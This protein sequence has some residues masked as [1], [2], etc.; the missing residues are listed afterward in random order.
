M[1]DTLN[2]KAKTQFNKL[3]AAAI[4]TLG[5]STSANPW[6]SSDIDKM[7][8]STDDYS[9]I[10]KAC[11]FFYKKDPII[12]STINK[13]VEIGINEL[14]F[15]SNGLS[16]N[17]FKIFLGLKESLEEFA[18][19][20]ALEYL[21]SGLVVPE[22]KYARVNKNVIKTL[23]IK[24]YETLML[25]VTMYIRDPE[26]IKIKKSPFADEPSYF[27]KVP[28]DLIFFIMNKGK[29]LDGTE[30]PDAY[31]KLLALYPEFVEAVLKGVKE[32]PIE[33]SSM[34]IR[35]K[36]QP[37]NP[38]P[39]PYLSATLESLK[40]KRNLRRMDYAIAARVIGAIQL[41]KL[42]S[43]E[44]PVTEDDK[45]EQ[46][47]AIKDQMLWRDYSGKDIE[48]IFQL[49]ANHTLSVEWIVPDTQALLDEQKY[50]SVNQDIIYSL[51]FP[52]ILIT[53]ESERTGTSD[54]QYAMM[55][56]S[57]TM[58]NFRKKILQVI[59]EVV[60]RVAE[61][62]N[63]KTAPEVKFK[64][65]TL[66]DHGTL[67]QSL[68]D[69]YGAGNISRTTYASTLGYDWDDE[70]ALRKEE[71]DKLEELGLDEFAPKPFSNQPGQGGGEEKDGQP[72]TQ[73]TPKSNI[74]AR[75]NNKT[76]KNT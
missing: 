65:L 37:D 50:V 54:P 1:N 43:D 3:A 40:H 64:P 32:F 76:G 21:I 19:A 39:I 66:F 57:R 69:L 71:K 26:T 31:A 9:K 72:T 13:L 68:S 48:R 62:N 14:I 7:E 35:R 20:M 24:K 5:G 34:I 38:Y 51:G 28:G 25:P 33:D 27:I 11:R 2:E 4:N 8:L 47:N 42:G 74:N 61:E 23:G 58:E 30:D 6:T 73:Q 18:E 75:G 46:F 60:R 44:F 17:E 12:S 45:D 59:K 49:F 53:G 10:I 56:P 67:L 55:S 36:Y 70:T 22:V 63:L 41:F 16:E 29:Y 15:S 52:R